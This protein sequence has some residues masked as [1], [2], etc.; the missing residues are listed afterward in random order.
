MAAIAAPFGGFLRG[1]DGEGGIDI[2]DVIAALG[3]AQ[4]IEDTVEDEIERIELG[5]QV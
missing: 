5:A 2:A 4:R 3:G 1:D